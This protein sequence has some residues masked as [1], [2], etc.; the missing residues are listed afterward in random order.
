MTPRRV[1]IRVTLLFIQSLPA[2]ASRSKMKRKWRNARDFFIR[3]HVDTDARGIRPLPLP[4]SYSRACSDRERDLVGERLS[5]RR[6][7]NCGI[8]R[9]VP[10][11]VPLVAK[12]RIVNSFGLSRRARYKFRGFLGE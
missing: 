1:S 4:L 8:R 5:V 6:G 9:G 12:P 7:C 3:A 11:F 10:S 2:C